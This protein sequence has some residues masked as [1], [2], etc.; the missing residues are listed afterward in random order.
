MTSFFMDRDL[1]ALIF[2]FV[3]YIEIPKIN[4]FLLIFTTIRLSRRKK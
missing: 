4:G 2:D 3:E 1:A